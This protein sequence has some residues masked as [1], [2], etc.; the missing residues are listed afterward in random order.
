M[1][2]QQELQVDF[3]IQK[4]FVKDFSF[5]SPNSPSLFAGDWKPEANIEL[6][7]HAEK[8]TET[9]HEVTLTVTVTAKC[10]D[11]TAFLIEVKQAG[12]FSIKGLP[13]ENYG[14]MLGSFCPNILFPYAREVIGATVAKGGFPQLALAPINFDALY[15]QSAEQQAQQSSSE[16][17]H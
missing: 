7:T 14:H 16:T 10:E 9:D 5:E 8:L 4:I 2:E 1:A 15:A 17:R 3:A 11:K 13:E 6:N 12:I